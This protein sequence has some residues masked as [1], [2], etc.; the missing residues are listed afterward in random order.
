[1]LHDAGRAA[2]MRRDGGRFILAR[3]RARL[4]RPVRTG[5]ASGPP[6]CSRVR[7]NRAGLGPRP[8]SRGRKPRPAG[9]EMPSELWR[10]C[11]AARCHRIAALASS[12]AA[13][14]CRPGAPRHQRGRL[15][16]RCNTPGK[17]CLMVM[18]EVYQA[19]GSL[20]DCA[21]RTW[22]D[23]G[24]AC[25]AKSSSPSA[26]CSDEPGGRDHAIAALPEERPRARR[27]GNCAPEIAARAP[28][29]AAWSRVSPKND[30]AAVP[31]H[32]RHQNCR[33]VERRD[34]TA[35]SR[36][37]PRALA[38]ELTS[39]GASTTDRDARRELENLEDGGPLLRRGTTAV[40]RRRRWH[41]A[42]SSGSRL[43]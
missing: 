24:D 13:L 3:F 27:P 32:E 5:P 23:A 28:D 40:G 18:G 34:S 36:R 6:R 35:H 14:E 1:M 37:V 33:L 22:S 39:R 38:S 11:L 17:H 8:R 42:T 20:R 2:S 31:R 7:S 30:R 16:S 9:S 4:V 41:V 26:A 15:D 29:S 21:G 19:V 43:E 10:P 25:T 12:A